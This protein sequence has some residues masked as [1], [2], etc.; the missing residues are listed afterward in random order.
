MG[1]LSV[2][3]CPQTVAVAVPSQVTQVWQAVPVAVPHRWSAPQCLRGVR[4]LPVKAITVATLPV[5]VAVQVAAAKAQQ[6]PPR[7]ATPVVPVVTVKPTQSPARRL[8]M[9]VAAVA[10]AELVTP[11]ERV[12]LVAVGAV[13]TVRPH[14][15]TE[16]TAWAAAVVA[17]VA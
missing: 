15:L 1:R 17:W 6:P 2:Q 13:A 12:E 5:G 7:R 8:P 14:R 9:Q 11:L 3:W 10:V 16:Q 4:V